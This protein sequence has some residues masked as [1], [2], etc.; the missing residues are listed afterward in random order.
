M[1]WVNATG[2][3]EIYAA[4]V[5]R[6]G[7]PLDQTAIPI[8]VPPR[9]RNPVG[10]DRASFLVVWSSYGQIRATKITRDGEIV[11]ERVI[12]TG[13]NSSVSCSPARCLVA[14]TSFAQFRYQ[15]VASMLD[16]DGE[17]FLENLLVASFDTQALEPRIATNGSNFLVAWQQFNPNIAEREQL[18]TWRRLTAGYG[19]WQS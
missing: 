8:A 15:T 1:T 18:Y 16:S 2:N 19:P 13:W 7:S 10:V 17:P 9:S 14:W 6:D 11:G 3:G 12:G 4:R 5:S